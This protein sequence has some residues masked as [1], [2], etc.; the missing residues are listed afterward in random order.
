MCGR[1]YIE[2]GAMESMDLSVLNR[3]ALGQ[4]DSSGDMT[5]GMSVPALVRGG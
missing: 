4:Q 5:P 2:D 1:Y 3:E